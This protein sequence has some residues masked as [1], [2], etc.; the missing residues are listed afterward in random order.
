MEPLDHGATMNRLEQMEANAAAA[1]RLLTLAQHDEVIDLSSCGTSILM[2]GAPVADGA[3]WSVQPNRG[4]HPW[5]WVVWLDGT[6]FYG[7]CNRAEAVAWG[8][9]AALVGGAS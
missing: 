3:A 2:I 9:P 6:P 4:T 8:C 1:R 7:V 5:K